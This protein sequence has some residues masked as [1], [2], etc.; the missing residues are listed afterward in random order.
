M[1][2]VAGDASRSLGRAF[3]DLGRARPQFSLPADRSPSSTHSEFSPDG[4]RFAW[5]EPDG[6][7]AVFDLGEIGRRLAAVGLGW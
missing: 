4:L 7:V 6:S 5:G 1:G 2:H 3:G